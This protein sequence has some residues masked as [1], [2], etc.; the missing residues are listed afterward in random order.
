M[1]VDYHFLINKITDMKCLYK[2]NCKCIFSWKPLGETDYMKCEVPC[3]S[4]CFTL[5][6]HS[7]KCGRRTVCPECP[8]SQVHFRALP[9]TYR[10]STLIH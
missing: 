8:R 6:K 3:I 4:C 5:W 9:M 7:A 10:R 1:L 2:K